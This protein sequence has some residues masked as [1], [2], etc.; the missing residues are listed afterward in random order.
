MNIITNYILTIFLHIIADF[1]LQGTLGDMKT[2]SW[3]EKVAPDKMYRYDYIVGLLV[4]SFMWSCIIVI[5]Y[6]IKTGFHINGWFALCIIVNTI[7]HAI[8]DDLKANKRKINLWDDQLLHLVQISL[9]NFVMCI[10]VK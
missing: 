5:P 2:K 7:I 8:I 10:I 6:F 1:K 4:H 3:W 9:T